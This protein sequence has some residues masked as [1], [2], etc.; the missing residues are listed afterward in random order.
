MKQQIKNLIDQ[1]KYEIKDNKKERKKNLK[2][3]DFTEVRPAS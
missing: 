3:E 2:Y 1:F